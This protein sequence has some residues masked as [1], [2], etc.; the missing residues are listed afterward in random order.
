MKEH[1][2]TSNTWVR[3]FFILIFALISIALR[4]VIG[5]TVLLQFG[6]LLFTGQLNEYLLDFGQKLSTYTYQIVRYLTF[7]SDEKPFPFSE[8]PHQ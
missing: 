2:T 1:L 8:W 3:G 6:F 7:N 5:I 4:I